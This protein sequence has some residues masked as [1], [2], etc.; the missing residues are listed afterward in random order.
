MSISR[1]TEHDVDLM[2]T[3]YEQ[4]STTTSIAGRFGTDS[5]TVSYHFK[6]RSVQCRPQS[7]NKRRYTLRED[8]FSNVSDEA[9]AYWLGY[10]F[11]DGCVY[12]RRDGNEKSLSVVSQN[13]DAHHL[14]RLAEFLG[15][16]KPLK[17][18]NSD[19]AQS[20]CVY[21]A[22]LVDDLLHL[23]CVPRKSSAMFLNPPRLADALFRHFVR[24]YFDGDGSAYIANSTPTG[25]LCG[26][27]QF[28]AILQGCITMQAKT[29]GIIY[30]H[31]IS[32]KAHY[33]VFRGKDKFTRFGAWMYQDASVFLPRKRER[34][35]AYVG[36]AGAV[37]EDVIH[38][39]IENQKGK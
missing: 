18:A 27:A 37:T 16:T 10:L 32:K 4:G 2:V 39:Y 33:L 12:V 29:D 34:F 6:K 23:G 25:S 20:L 19:T 3:L 15:T 8:A 13:K 28:L 21:S 35:N 22:R 5:G 36:A 11:A 9:T 7:E 14:V 1:F 38:R 17:S 24:G 30:P 26:N 31:T